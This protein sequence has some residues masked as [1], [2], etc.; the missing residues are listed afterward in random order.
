LLGTL[1]LWFGWYGFNSGSALLAG[2]AEYGDILAT[3]AGTNTTLSA[4]AGGIVALFINF[5]VVQRLTGESQYDLVKTMNGVL[6]GLVAITASCALVEPWQ[7]MLIGTVAGALYLVASWSIVLCKLDDAVDAIPVHLVNGIWG[8]LAT[9]LFATEKRLEQA[10]GRNDHPGLFYTGDFTLLCAQMVGVLYNIGWT[11]GVMLPFFV[12]LEKTGHFRADA[13]QEVVGLDRAYFGGL[14]MGG[15][16]EDITPDQ[17]AKLTNELEQHLFH[18]KPNKDS[19][20]EK[21]E[22]PKTEPRAKGT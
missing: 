1:I 18:R 21:A 2:G 13:M 10:Y 3:Y 6:S 12:I 17:I 16:D 14:Q 11:T 5:I 20:V 9:G 15:G 7:A 8:M 19:D 4:G 22:R